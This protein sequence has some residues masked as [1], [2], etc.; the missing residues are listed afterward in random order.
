MATAAP[1]IAPDS[2]GNTAGYAS[3]CGVPQPLARA[4]LFCFLTCEAL[5]VLPQRVN[6]QE[7]T[8]RNGKM[9]QSGKQG[10]DG[11]PERCCVAARKRHEKK[12]RA[13]RLPSGVYSGGMC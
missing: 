6:R 8:V 4:D 7:R 10:Q 5:P 1:R 13:Q 12:C 3:L 9:Q 2:V 11:L